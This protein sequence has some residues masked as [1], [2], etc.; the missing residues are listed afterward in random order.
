MQCNIKCCC[1][2]LAK[3]YISENSTLPKVISWT[4][5]DIHIALGEFLYITVWASFPPFHVQFHR[6]LLQNMLHKVVP[7]PDVQK[8]FNFLMCQFMC[9]SIFQNNV[10][11]KTLSPWCL[12]TGVLY[13]VSGGM[14]LDHKWGSLGLVG[15]NMSS[16]CRLVGIN[17]YL[18]YI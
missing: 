10:L 3:K 13:L 1:N 14:V 16:Y 5:L 8:Y 2:G 15:G 9:E 18:A 6:Q 17:L 11:L 4:Q 12:V 7:S